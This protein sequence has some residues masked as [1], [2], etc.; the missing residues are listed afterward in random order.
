ME[1]PA[2]LDPTKRRDVD[3]IDVNGE[4]M[5]C[6]SRICVGSSLERV[7]QSIERYGLNLPKLV[8][9]RKRVM[10]DITDLH[11]SLIDLVV[12]GQT[13]PNAADALPI[14]RQIEQLRRT[15]LPYS[16]YSKAARARLADLGLSII[17]AQP[18]D[19]SPPTGV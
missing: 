18:E 12:A 17:C 19:M 3:L 6:P 10:R 1:E 9:A 5:M 7:E 8:S 4:A 15:T 11:T 16:P 14:N 2:L 13:H